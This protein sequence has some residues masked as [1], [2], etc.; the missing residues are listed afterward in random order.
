M[1]FD[2]FA[3]Q[4]ALALVLR[5]ETLMWLAL[6]VTLGVG[7]GAMP[8]LTTSTGLAL[9]LPLTFGMDTANALGLLIGLYKGS[10]WGGS[11]SA[12]SFATPGAP[13]SA[14]TVYDGY[15]LMEKGKGKKAILVALY[16]SVTSDFLSD[17]V[18]IIA[19]PLLAIVALKFGPSEKFWL[20]VLAVALL[21]ALSGAHL[22]KG[23]LSAAIGLFIGTVGTDPV[24]YVERVTFGIW[25]LNEG[26]QL[27]PLIIGIFAMSRMLEESLKLFIERKSMGD[28]QERIKAM[29]NKG[30]EGL[31]FA[32]FRSCWKEMVI[33]FGCGTIIGALPGLGATVAAFVS[34]SVAKQVSPEKKIGT[35]RIE[36]IAAA[37]AGN[38][39]TVGP[40]LIPLLAFGIP[41]SS[42]AALIGAALTLQGADPNPRFFSLYPEIVY[43]LFMIL[44]LGNAFNLVIGRVFGL[45][46]ARLGQLPR[47]M[48]IP[49]VMMMAIV[50][51]FVYR[52]EFTDV[53]VMLFFGFVGFFL[54]IFGV[55]E[56]P[57]V[58]T[59][60]VT[61]LMEQNIRRA[62]LI[63]QGSLFHALFTSPLAICL[64]LAAVIL[65]YLSAKLQVMERIAHIEE[66]DAKERNS[67]QEARATAGGN[68]RRPSDHIDE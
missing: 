18:T 53:Y 38:N 28:M 25:W 65:T 39:A 55:P 61:P 2:A 58:V 42:A 41:G 23:M 49:L 29:F 67:A 8:G 64:A 34:Y 24:A 5:P 19:A 52:G 60:M 44:M 7:V 45:L 46:Y 56:A 27:V 16:S 30:S 22:A 4:E 51:S 68:Q 17:V 48:L 20:M 59:Y 62:L 1:V 6:G 36:G 11:I 13:D 10:I 43:S 40:T 33:G 15:K 54:R 9:F 12:I 26:V 32:E 35:G 47:E 21:G 3:F 50:G 57:L 66:Q 31:T 14:A 63:E 37:E